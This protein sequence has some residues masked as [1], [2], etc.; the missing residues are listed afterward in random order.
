MITNHE[1]RILNN[2]WQ[3]IISAIV[4]FL[5]VILLP[6]IL[7]SLTGRSNNP[8]KKKDKS[9]Y[10]DDPDEFIVHKKDKEG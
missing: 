9:N 7:P 1:E 5:S 6:F 8:K 3:Y 2:N 4:T 10:S